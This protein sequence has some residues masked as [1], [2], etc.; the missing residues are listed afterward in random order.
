MSAPDT[1]TV[2]QLADAL[3]D[4]EEYPSDI[5]RKRAAVV[6]RALVEEE[7]D[8]LRSGWM[9]ERSQY[10]TQLERKDDRIRGSHR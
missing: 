7:R 3:E 10:L 9:D 2:T 6:L 1:A 8:R 4:V 5:V